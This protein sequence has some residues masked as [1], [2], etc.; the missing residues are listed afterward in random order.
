MQE[1]TGGVLPFIRVI[2][3]RHGVSPTAMF[4]YT[5]QSE[6]CNFMGTLHGGALAT[7]FDVCNT[8]SLGMVGRRDWG[9]SLGIG[10]TQNITVF[11][12]AKLRQK[13]IFDVEISHIGSTSCTMRAVMRDK[14]SG[15]MLA[16]CEHGRLNVGSKL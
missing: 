8:I 10:Q 9:E 2:N 6:H 1:W 16:V 5:V 3:A 14:V 13:V 12:A 11:H 15:Q 4:E 7:L